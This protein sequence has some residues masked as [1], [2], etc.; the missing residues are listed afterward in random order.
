LNGRASRSTSSI[1]GR[2][3][4]QYAAPSAW[5]INS[6]V[7]KSFASR[8]TCHARPRRGSSRSV[9]RPPRTP[10]REPSRRSADPR[11]RDSPRSRATTGT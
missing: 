11:R 4:T 5:G 10:R 2:V 1:T 8:S 3:A 6:S 9:H 7:A